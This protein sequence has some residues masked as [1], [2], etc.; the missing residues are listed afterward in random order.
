LLARA[1]EA[2][3]APAVRE[4]DLVAARDEL[5]GEEHRHDLEDVRRTA[6]RQRKGRDSQE[7]DEQQGEAPLLEELDDAPERLLAVA[8]QPTLELVAGRAA[9]TRMHGPAHTVVAWHGAPSSAFCVEATT[10]A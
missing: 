8:L 4:P 1:G 5:D 9:G 10:R 3:S 2:K 7:Q 6:G